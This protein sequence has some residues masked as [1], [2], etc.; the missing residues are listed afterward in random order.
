MAQEHEKPGASVHDALDHARTATQELHKL[1]SAMRT[2]R[3]A[4]AD[5]EAAIKKAKE[6]A[7]LTRSAMQERQEEWIKQQ[8]KE[9]VGKLE[10][11]EKNAVESLKSHG[12]AAHANISKALADA[13]TA[14]QHISVA[15]AAHRSQQAAKH[16]PAK[17]AS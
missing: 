4:K 7:E 13:R 14:V 8:L 1:I 2:R 6:A 9:A 12:E 5:V 17:R 3:A 10:A 15:V 11:S 16:A